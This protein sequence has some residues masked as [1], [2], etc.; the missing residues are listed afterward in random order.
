MDFEEEKFKNLCNIER[1]KGIYKLGIAVG[2]SGKGR[3][4]KDGSLEGERGDR[5]HVNITGLELIGETD[6]AENQE[7]EERERKELE[8]Q[9]LGLMALRGAI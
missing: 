9:I 5:S 3:R 6:E 1:V 4:R 7:R 2:K 8:V